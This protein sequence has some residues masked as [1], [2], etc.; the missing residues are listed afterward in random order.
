CAVTPAEHLRLPSLSDIREGLIATKL[1][2]HVGDLEKGVK[3][4]WKHNMDMDR[5]RAE[6]DWKTQECLALDPD[7]VREFRAS[8]KL[9]DDETCSMCGKMCAVKISREAL[10][11]NQ[12]QP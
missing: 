4:A 2:A 8:V 9:A 11:A 1:A 7:R 5:A 12:T 3:S 6:C 10:T